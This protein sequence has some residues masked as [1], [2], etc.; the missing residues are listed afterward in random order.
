MYRYD[1]FDRAFVAE[2]VAQ[3]RDQVARRVSGELSEEDFRPLTRGATGSLL[4]SP[5][6]VLAGCLSSGGIALAVLSLGTDRG[7]FT[8]A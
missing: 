6:P 3:F 5:P 8:F 1:G 4:P 7:T 2:R